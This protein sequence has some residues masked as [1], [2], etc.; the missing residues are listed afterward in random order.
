MLVR[1]L[2][3]NHA[4]M[5]M[6]LIQVATVSTD[7]LNPKQSHDAIRVTRPTCLRAAGP[8]NHSK[9]STL[10]LSTLDTYACKFSG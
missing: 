3:F 1:R 10:D 8:L 2:M 6:M 5:V 7:S 4:W 9:P